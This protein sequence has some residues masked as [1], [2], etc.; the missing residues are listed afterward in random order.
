V[1]CPNSSSLQAHDGPRSR[2]SMYGLY[3]YLYGTSAS[4]VRHFV[5][6]LVGNTNI[7]AIATSGLSRSS[8]GMGRW[9]CGTCT[10]RRPRRRKH[11]MSLDLVTWIRAVELLAADST[12]NCVKD[13]DG[14]PLQHCTPLPGSS[15]LLLL[16][17]EPKQNTKPSISH[18]RRTNSSRILPLQCLDGN[19]IS[20]ICHQL[21]RVAQFPWCQYAHEFWA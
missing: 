16:S 12:L 9:E 4:P 19:S 11:S 10:R 1:R 6:V 3:Q 2:L 20:I 13:H 15:S 18:A 17:P 21:L 8:S 14:P 5:F 7:S